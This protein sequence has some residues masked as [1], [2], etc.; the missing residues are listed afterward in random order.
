M[1]RSLP[2]APLARKSLELI[3]VNLNDI[4]GLQSRPEELKTLGKL[5]TEVTF[6]M[7]S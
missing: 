2:K 4:S 1:D 3:G 7:P 5:D 6:D